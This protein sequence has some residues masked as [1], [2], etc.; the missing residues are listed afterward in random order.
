[1]AQL[2]EGS[3]GDSKDSETCKSQ[4]MSLTWERD[5]DIIVRF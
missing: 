5:S 4:L 3:T 1:M 2:L